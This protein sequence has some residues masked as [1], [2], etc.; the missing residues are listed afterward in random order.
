MNRPRRPAMFLA[1]AVILIAAIPALSA[2][3]MQIRVHLDNKED[4]LKFTSLQP[5][6]AWRGDGWIEVIGSEKDQDEFE[7]LG[8]RTEVIHPDLKA[9]YRSRLAD[10]DMGGYLTLAEVW[11]SVDVISADHP[12]IVTGRQ[13][14]GN[15][16]EGR[17]MFALKISDNPTVDEAEPEVMYTAAIHAREVITPLVLLHVMNYL[18]DNYGVLPEVTELVDERELWFVPMVNPDGYYHNQVTDPN[19]GGMWRKNRR[20]NG[21]GTYGVDLN[22]NFGYEWGYDDEGSSPYTDDPTYRGPSAFS[23]PELQN[24]KA[25]TQAHTF[26]STVYLH[27][28]SNLVLWPWGYDYLVTPDEPLFS[29]MGDSMSAY[30]GYDPGPA[31]SL[32]PANGVSDDWGYGEQVLKNKNLAFTFE[33][34][35]YSDGFWPDPS[36][37][38]DLVAENLQPCLF[39]ARTAD[40]PYKLLPP[41]PPAAT[42]ADTVDAASYDLDWTH[43]DSDNPALYFAVQELSGWERTTDYADDFNSWSSDGFSI[44]NSFSVSSPSSFYSGSGNNLANTMT[45][46][47]PVS[48]QSGDTLRVWV[49]YDIEE[50]WDYAYVEVST[51]G[52]DFSPIEGSITTDYDPHG[53]NRG[54]GITGTQDTW[55][56]ATFDLGPWAGQ[57]VYF[58][59]SYY[60]DSYVDYDGIWFDDFYPIEDFALSTIVDDSIVGNRYTFTD[61]MDGEFF[62]RVR[63][64][65]AEAQVSAWSNVVSTIVVDTGIT[66]VDSDGDGFGD[67]GHPENDC[68]DDNCPLV[69]NEDQIDA[70]SDGLGDACDDCPSDPDNDIDGDSICGDI[71]NCPDVYNPDQTVSGGLTMGDACCC[72]VRGDLN[73][74]GAIDIE[75]LVYLANYMFSGGNASPCPAE[76]DMNGNATEG[77]IEDLVYLATYMFQ[78]GPPPA[79]CP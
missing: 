8:L 74:S 65:D 13:F 51:N 57:S 11:D 55:L 44:S 26:V 60:T 3:V 4:Y 7:S 23:E 29:I 18:T 12:N 46:N 52:T 72:E 69:Y 70:D 59:L 71:D 1:I 73:R 61:H 50:N 22:R 41:N 28:Y 15:T 32:Y 54:N 78:G 19:G 77:D 39:L 43:S 9:H 37:I 56:E 14:I 36:R 17:Q 40:N 30:N 47:S 38:P 75:D 5:D 20:D 58:R 68:P 63:A 35:G 76:S 16:H 62:Y 42:I 48:V 25:F 24:M 21:D 45:T 64:Y 33:I 53:N 6:I 31:H 49:L 67:P 27:S 10:K 79:D 2:D 34:G 66:C